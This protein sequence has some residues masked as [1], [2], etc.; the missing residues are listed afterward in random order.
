[1]Q[2]QVD[3]IG[4]EVLEPRPAAGRV[5]DDEGDPVAPQQCDERRIDEARVADLDRVA[6]RPDAIDL[7]PG[8]AGEALVMAAR[9]R[10]RRVAVARQHRE[11]GVEALRV[12]AELRRELPQDRPSLSRRRSTP[13]AKK[14]A[15]GAPTFLSFSMW[16]M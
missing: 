13:E 4:G 15:S 9:Q 11:E 5:G 16:V 10:E 3:E 14:L 1:V 6:Q 12:E 7:E 2:A 8:A